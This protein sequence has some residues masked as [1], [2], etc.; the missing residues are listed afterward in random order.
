MEEYVTTH[1]ASHPTGYG[2]AEGPDVGM[3]TQSDGGGLGGWM[4]SAFFSMIRT[5]GYGCTVYLRK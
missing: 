2:L 1:H 5:A 4:S 3:Q